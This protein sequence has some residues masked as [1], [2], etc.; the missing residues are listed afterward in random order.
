MKEN[1]RLFFG[2]IKPFLICIGLALFF[3]GVTFPTSVSHAQRRGKGEWVLPENYPDGFDGWGHIG[4]IT[5]EK[6][7]IDDTLLRLSPYV[8]FHMPRRVYASRA[9]FRPGTLVAYIT[10]SEREIVSLWLIESLK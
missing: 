2:R 8:T 3:F 9:R 6:V 5:T 1:D 7:V 4:R 10:N